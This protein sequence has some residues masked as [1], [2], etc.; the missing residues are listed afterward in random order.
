MIF[1]TML[2]FLINAYLCLVIFGNNPVYKS[3]I[4][5][6]TIIIIPIDIILL[7]LVLFLSI[8]NKN[9]AYLISCIVITI[10]FFLLRILFINK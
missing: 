8:R 7:L 1:F 3:D 6:A 5:I 4:E 2:L 9:Y 10:P